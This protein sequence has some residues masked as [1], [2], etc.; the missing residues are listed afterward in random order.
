MFIHLGADRLVKSKDVIMIINAENGLKAA[1]T[2]EFL[3]NSS[4]EPNFYL[5]NA[6]SCKSV[7]ITDDQIYYSPISSQTL[8]KRASFTQD[9]GEA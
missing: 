7:V 9:L 5:Y 3:K 4:N 2:V 8:K 6:D 1:S